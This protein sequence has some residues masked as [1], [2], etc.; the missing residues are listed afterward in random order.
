MAWEVWKWLDTGEV[1]FRVH[2][3]SRPASIPNPFVW[4]GFRLFGA[5][6]R[7]VFLES[8]DARMLR[9]TELALA[10][11][12]GNDPIR[13]AAADLTARQ[14]PADDVTADELAR[15]LGEGGEPG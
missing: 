13:R 11:D 12:A 2:A 6:E 3:V 14:L 7:R 9:F 1:E 4:I 10:Q 5:H 15:H 8:T